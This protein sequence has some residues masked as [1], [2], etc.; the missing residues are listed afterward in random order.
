MKS[1]NIRREEDRLALVAKEFRW[2][3]I[4]PRGDRAG[5]IYSKHRTIEAADRAARGYE[6]SIR[7]LDE[8]WI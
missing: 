3:L 6:V 5:Q 8:R 1:L 7:S 4:E 2:A